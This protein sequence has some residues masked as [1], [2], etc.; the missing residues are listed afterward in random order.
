MVDTEGRTKE[1]EV[2]KEER[3][4][5]WL[6]CTRGGGGTTGGQVSVRPS[7]TRYKLSFD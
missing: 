4:E 2:A 1:G 6:G 7:L 3:I 5:G